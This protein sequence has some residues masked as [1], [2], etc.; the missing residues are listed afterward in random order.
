MQMHPLPTTGLMYVGNN[1]QTQERRPFGTLWVS[2]LL[3]KWK[4]T[5]PHAPTI[6][7]C[8]FSH[9]NRNNCLMMK[10]ELLDYVPIFPF[11]HNNCLMLT[12]W[13]VTIKE[14][15]SK[16]CLFCSWQNFRG[17]QILSSHWKQTSSY[18]LYVSL[19]KPFSCFM[20]HN[21]VCD[22]G[23]LFCD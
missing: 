6:L 9:S 5:W 8:R 2:A 23:L 17:S 20:T 14:V 3:M 11:F 21:F 19:L 15:K 1:P 13:L 16:A 12:V 4:P 18:C 10:T 22:C 7:E